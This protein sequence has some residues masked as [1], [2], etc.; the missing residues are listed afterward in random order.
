[1]AVL[2]RGGGPK[3][4]KMCTGVEVALHVEENDDWWCF[5]PLVVIKGREGGDFSYWPSHGGWG[6]I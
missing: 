6:V 2:A 5:K 4:K 1:M 3:L